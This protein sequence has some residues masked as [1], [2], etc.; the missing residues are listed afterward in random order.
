MTILENKMSRLLS[1]LV[2]TLGA[3]GGA[4]DTVRAGE[5]YEALGYLTYNAFGPSGKAVVKRV[6]MFDVKVGKAWCVRTEP[7]VECKGGIGYCETFAYTNDSIWAVTALAPA[8]NPSE[9]PFQRLRSE[10]KESKKE[11]VFFTNASF[12]FPE[13]ESRSRTTAKS[14]R[15]V[16]NVAIA[17]GLTSKYPPMD[18]S[19]AAFF[20]FAFTPPCKRDD[21]TNQM[22]LQIWD[23]GNP[24]SA[25]FRRATWTQFSEPPNL[26]SSVVYN[27]VGRE[28]FSDGTA[29]S[30][31]LRDVIHPLET[32]ARYQV[33]CTTNF[34]GLVLPTKMILAR[35][36]S[37]AAGNGSPKVLTTD[38][39][40]V[41]G[42]R[43]LSTDETFE[44][45]LPGKTWISDYRISAGEANGRPINY[46]LDGGILP[47]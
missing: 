42:V 44:A 8:Y 5:G 18:P 22:L 15:S 14:E 20:W 28:L 31:T 2:I 19:Y 11:D 4:G 10:L 45:R 26:V 33:E 16:N 24:L 35:F 17:K 7:V 43:L 34:N 47:Q 27:W 21:G 23:E 25:R 38:I 39:A 41:T 1:F 30:I 40:F 36:D 12:K 13:L 46:L 9:S 3:L 6:L 37:K 29:A 32:A